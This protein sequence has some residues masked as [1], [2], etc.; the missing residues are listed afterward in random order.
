MLENIST[1]KFF[2]IPVDIVTSNISLVN[3]FYSK[4]IRFSDMDD[5]LS[6]WYIW[7]M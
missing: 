5:K 4:G 3:I 7:H 2:Q 6:N 1:L